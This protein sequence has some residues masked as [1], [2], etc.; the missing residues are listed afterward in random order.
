MCL[1][2]HKYTTAGIVD[3]R[4]F[5]NLKPGGAAVSSVSIIYS[6]IHQYL[7]ALLASAWAWAAVTNELC[8]REASQ[9]HADSVGDCHSCLDCRSEFPLPGAFAVLL[10]GGNYRIKL[11]IWARRCGINLSLPIPGR[12]GECPVAYRTWSPGMVYPF[13][14][15]PGRAVRVAN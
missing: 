7:W 15:L 5:P 1:I 10:P 9:C 4:Y 6:R 11:A 3:I 2:S 8:P 14:C 12:A 13:P